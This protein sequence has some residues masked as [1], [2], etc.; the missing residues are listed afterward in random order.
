MPTIGNNYERLQGIQQEQEGRNSFSDLTTTVNG[1]Y[2]GIQKAEIEGNTDVSGVSNKDFTD[3]ALIDTI[4]NEDPEIRRSLA[5]STSWE[6]LERKRAWEKEKS[7]ATK[8]ALNTYGVPGMLAAGITVGALDYDAPLAVLSGGVYKGVTASMKA[9][10]LSERMSKV[11]AASITGAGF[12]LANN[13][14]YETVTNT[15]IEDSNIE[16]TALGFAF[17]GALSL[18]ATKVPKTR[19]T[20]TDDAGIKVELSKTEVAAKEASTLEESHAILAKEHSDTKG[21][22]QKL[23]ETI[24]DHKKQST[25]LKN[26]I[27]TIKKDEA[28]KTIDAIERT[29]VRASIK[30]LNETIKTVKNRLKESEYK[31]DKS[32]EDTN[33]LYK[34]TEQ[35]DGLKKDNKRLTAR[36]KGLKGSYY[37]IDNK[38]HVDKAKELN[39]HIDKL[40][41]D[42][43][44]HNSKINEHS[45]SIKGDFTPKLKRLKETL[46]KQQTMIEALHDDIKESHKSINV[47]HKVYESKAAG[48]DFGIM[49]SLFISPKMKLYAS[50][51]PAVQGLVSLLE[52]SSIVGISTDGK[53]VKNTKNA[54]TIKDGISRMLAQA[55][56]NKEKT[57]VVDTYFTAVEKGEFTGTYHE[58]EAKVSNNS[59]TKIGTAIEEQTGAFKRN[60]DG[61][62]YEAKRVEEL[63][64]VVIKYDTS[65]L[66]KATKTILD[67]YFGVI[68][69]RANAAGMDKF[70][71]IHGIYLPHIW[72]GTAMKAPDAMKRLVDAQIRYAEHF[73]LEVDTKRF[74][75]SAKAAIESSQDGY[76]QVIH[77]I[78]DPLSPTQHK[79]SREKS[80]SIQVFD[81]DVADLFSTNLEQ[82]MKGYDLSMS[83]K[84]ALQETVGLSSVDDIMQT[85]VSKVTQDPMELA[86]FKTLLENLTG[87]HE[88]A[89]KRGT[90]AHNVMQT[91]TKVTSLAFMPGFALPAL[92]EI[93]NATGLTGYSKVM[94]D[95]FG[96][97]KTA[98]DLIRGK[99]LSVT[100]H[101]DLIGVAHIGSSRWSFH[102]NRM[103]GDMA[104][105]STTA[106]HNML[107][108]ANHKASKLFGLQPVTEASR[109][110]TGSSGVNWLLDM[111]AN[112]YKL[113]SMDDKKLA[114]LGLDRQDLLKINEARAHVE[115]DVDDKLIDWHM[116][117][118]DPETHDMMRDALYE[119]INASILH[120]DAAS[121][122][123]W[124]T[125]PDSWIAKIT[126]QFM[127]FPMDSYE[128]LT[129][130]GL[131]EFDGKQVGSLVGNIALWYMVS[132]FRDALKLE[133]KQRYNGEDG[134]KQQFQDVIAMSSLAGGPISMVSKA[135]SIG[136]GNI[137][138]SDYRPG[139]SSTL[140]GASG[141][142]LDKAT[143]GQAPG[144]YGVV[145][146]RILEM[147]LLND[148][149]GD[150]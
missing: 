116:E 92:T 63:E 43:S 4:K 102:V 89:T 129:L 72:D 149:T 144:L 6:N 88:I 110:L 75:A 101:N 143:R 16:A 74:E 8:N 137:L 115:Y 76:Q 46:T 114:R 98:S 61:I 118:W 150:D 127:R 85:I 109:I 44:V 117:K 95:Q 29:K 111:A 38:S 121:L 12:S 51:N 3:E 81:H 139:A 27:N 67:G 136:T 142:V 50:Q 126:M 14:M 105:N 26:E 59:Y 100:A 146:D 148:Y 107:D 32:I 33:T 21:I 25:V 134:A 19:P 97:I 131:S 141:S 108:S 45:A 113:S 125:E 80:R 119:H 11:S 106:L 1:I 135:Y 77:K 124:I 35:L 122:P 130:R 20:I 73:N 78:R 47:L 60:Q 53:Y 123:M 103:D 23:T 30:E 66:D 37:E 58:W 52:S 40:E 69:K 18:W 120:P 7:A 13:I 71:A 133:D 104:L 39:A 55:F 91:L 17:G 41:S 93:T 56:T 5:G 140:S 24:K 94:K 132:S 49:N 68:S 54:A 79:T 10:K 42:L 84:L 86:R 36:T 2:A 48:M 31:G 138:G 147:K 99:S 128:K 145:Q 22:I 57:G 83:G 28:F 15:H 90:M 87:S 112:P 34:L 65:E 70:G 82:V 62:D 96:A 64:K 9:L